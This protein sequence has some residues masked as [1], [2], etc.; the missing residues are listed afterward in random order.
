[1]IPRG[2]TSIRAGTKMHSETT[3]KRGQNACVSY[4]S[5]VFFC[6][7]PAFRSGFW[8]HFRARAKCSISPGKHAFLGMRNRIQKGLCF[9]GFGD[10]SRP[11]NPVKRRPF[12][13]RF[14]TPGKACFPGDILQ[15][16]MA[17]KFIQKPLQNA[18]RMHVFRMD[19][20]FSSALS[21]RFVVVS[22][23]IFV[24]ARNAVYPLGNTP[25]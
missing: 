8:I 13:M 23:Y 15:F 14:R 1:M 9:T 19:P 21:P 16:A 5:H 6:T 10:E 20:M 18:C 3:T 17:Q 22:G 25:F 4:G 24:P 2:Y 11:R 7:F 12:W